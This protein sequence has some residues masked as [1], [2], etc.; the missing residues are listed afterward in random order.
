VVSRGFDVL[1]LFWYARP[2]NSEAEQPKMTLSRRQVKEALETVPIDQVLMIAGELTPKQKK[3]SRLIASGSKGA[4]AYRQTYS[5]KA[6]PKTAG[7]AAS[8]LKKDS[9]ITAEIEAYRLANE[10]A[11]Y[12]TPQ[13][14]RDL[15][16][17]SLVQVVID[18]DAKHAQRVQ[19]AR[20]LGTVSEVAAFTERR[21]ITHVKSADDAKA[22]IMAKLRELM[23]AGATD[24]T[25]RE[26]D[27]L[28]LELT[29]NVSTPPLD[30]SAE[31]PGSTPTPR[32]GVW[33]PS[34]T[35]HSIPLNQSQ[36]KSTPTPSFPIPEAV[37]PESGD[38]PHSDVETK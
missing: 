30:E 4:E 20:V 21:E 8:K 19:A 2:V 14:L 24:T 1:G 17:H 16:I 5:A 23:N 25:A 6:K 13:Q 37:D 26:V 9:R 12:R 28:E 35:I 29:G 31:A 11:A 7:D 22:A 34:N 10:A 18:P 33:S 15:V 3:F 32:N 38:T 27:T 36:P